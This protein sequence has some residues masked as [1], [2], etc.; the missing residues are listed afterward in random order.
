MDAEADE[1]RRLVGDF[2]RRRDERS[3]RE[4]YRRH[5]GAMYL[6]ARRLL[7]P[8][9]ERAEEVVQE[10]WVLAVRGLAGFRW[11]A[12]LRTWLCGIVVN[13]C[14]EAQRGGRRQG[15]DTSV[16]LSLLP[17]ED[18]AARDA[19]PRIDLERAIAR[20]PS[21]SREVL[22]LHDIEGRTHEEIAALLGITDGA[23][24]SRLHKARRAMREF[25]CSGGR[26]HVK[27]S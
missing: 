26:T 16:N 5:T 19:V 3:F 11:D 21:G 4:I 18:D 14:R 17:M 27:R 7:G 13:R 8:S 6:L 25:L 22:V 12:T 20:L 15:E 2:L 9:Q 24:K 1:D 10:A 23:S